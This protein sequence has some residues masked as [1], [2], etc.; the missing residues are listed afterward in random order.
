MMEGVG[1]SENTEEDVETG[2]V[3]P[4]PL[5][6]ADVHLESGIGFLMEIGVKTGL[7]AE[8]LERGFFS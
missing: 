1:G 6:D 2:K 7:L 5:S 3:N 4:E 8:E